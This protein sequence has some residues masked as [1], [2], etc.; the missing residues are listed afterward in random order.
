M[1]TLKFL[2]RGSAFNIKEGNTSA[3]IKQDNYL[4]LID[5]GENIFERIIKTNLLDGIEKVDVLITHL[6]SDHVGSL[7]SLIYYCYYVKKF[8]INVYFPTYELQNLLKLMGHTRDEYIFKFTHG[9]CTKQISDNIFIKAIKTNHINTMN[10]YGYC[11]K[12][13]NEDKCLYYS[14]DSNI[15]EFRGK[16]LESVDE[17]YQ[18]TC[19][20]DYEGN[21]HLSLKKLCE[22]VPKEFRSKVYCIHIDRDELIDNAK[23]E[24][25]N[26]V[27]LA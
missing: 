5:C 12:L 14:G 2:G 3:Y 16:L 26:V 10:C 8:K 19:F 23:D 25:F 22:D 15:F 11:I 27:E 4:L 21:V 6:N 18:D 7:S 13:K 24:G 17:I 1:Q 9:Y 20:A